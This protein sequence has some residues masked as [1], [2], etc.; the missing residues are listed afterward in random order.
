MKFLDEIEN[1]HSLKYL[2]ISF[3]IY[4]LALSLSGI[5]LPVYFLNIGLS[6]SEILLIFFFTVLVIGL[7]P[8]VLVRI[9]TRSFEKLVTVGI[10]LASLFFIALL[11][12]KN[13]LFLGLTYGTFLGVFWPS[14]N[15]LTYRLTHSK[16]RAMIITF[17]TVLLPT[18]TGIIGPLAGGYLI[19]VFSFNTVFYSGIV[20][21]MIAAFFSLKVKFE[22]VKIDFK[23][24]K[25]TIFIVF[26]LAFAVNGVSEHFWLGYPLL[27]KNLSND[28]FEMGILASVTSLFSSISAVIVARFS[29]IKQKRIE[30]IT[31]GF[32]VAAIYFLGLAFTKTVS[33]L[34][35]MSIIGGV[36]TAFSTPLSVVF[37]DSFDKKHYPSFAVL[38]EAFIMFGR[39]GNIFL[40][41]IF[42]ISYNFQ[43]YFL[44]MAAFVVAV[45]PFLLIFRIRYHL[46]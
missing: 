23:F 27:L 11:F 20:L 31:I 7:L 24:P 2:A 29:D 32:V 17:L 46:K 4:D 5:F 22:T 40:M 30:F 8:S 26:L 41:Y 14:Y 3:F 12:T 42:L 37:A 43:N 38:K 35:F 45:I 44:S 25:S 39:F 18:I 16:T 9:F 10:L 28:I 13:P 34:L 19:Q 21:M 6:I 33:Q 36:A 1:L 15:L